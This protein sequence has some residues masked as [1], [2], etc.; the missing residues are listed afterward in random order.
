M[1]EI[2]RGTEA[3]E[4]RAPCLRSVRAVVGAR[5]TGKVRA[6]AV[7]NSVFH[8]I[9]FDDEDRFVRM[10]VPV[11]RDCRPRRQ[12]GEDSGFPSRWVAVKD[13]ERYTREA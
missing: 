13:A 9:A 7:G 12:A 1:D 3:R 11:L 8:E 4:Q 10:G 5:P 6:G 2:E